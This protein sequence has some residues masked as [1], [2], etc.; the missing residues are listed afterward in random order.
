MLR[1]INDKVANVRM[2]AA[3]GIGNIIAATNAVG[4]TQQ[5]AVVQAQIT[6]ALEKRLQEEDDIDCRAA[7]A[8][9][10]QGGALP[11]DM[12]G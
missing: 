8:L 7:Y 10:L 1:G 6:P 3:L 4:D 5:Q 12:Q 2:V 9:A 11:P